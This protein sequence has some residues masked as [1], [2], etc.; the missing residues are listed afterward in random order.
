VKCE[1]PFIYGNDLK[2]KISERLSRKQIPSDYVWIG[3]VS[4][5]PWEECDKIIKYEAPKRV[6][7][8]KRKK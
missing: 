8:K 5:L 3:N 7:K 1:W 6:K 4:T 2:K